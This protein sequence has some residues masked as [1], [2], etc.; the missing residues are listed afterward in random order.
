MTYN[1][2]VDVHCH[3]CIDLM[4]EASYNARYMQLLSSHQ[5][6]TLTEAAYNAKYMY[7]SAK[8]YAS[9]LSYE[10][11]VDNTEFLSCCLQEIRGYYYQRVRNSKQKMMITP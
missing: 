2:L 4:T 10:L 11:L 7:I 5:C 3:Q 8:R 6:I 9:P 1:L